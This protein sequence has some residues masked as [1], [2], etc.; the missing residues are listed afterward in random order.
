MRTATFCLFILLPLH[1]ISQL[2]L[3]WE[4]TF[5]QSQINHSINT[6]DKGSISIGTKNNQCWVMKNSMNGVIEWEQYFDIGYESG[7]GKYI[8]EHSDGVYIISADIFGKQWNDDNDPNQL[9]LG[10][11][12][13]KIDQHGELFYKYIHSDEVWSFYERTLQVTSDSLSIGMIRYNSR[14]LYLDKYEHITNDFSTTTYIQSGKN[15]IP[16]NWSFL[17]N[18]KNKTILNY[19]YLDEGTLVN[20]ITRFWIVKRLAGLGNMKCPSV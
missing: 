16:S 4:N 11:Y 10:A 19:T 18:E 5:D 1:L 2:T 9:G 17:K 8:Y 20:S 14:G 15:F 6:L 7:E 13:A 12:I 3:L